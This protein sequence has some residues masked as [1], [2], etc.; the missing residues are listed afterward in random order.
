VRKEAISTD[1]IRL[2]FRQ[3]WN[4]SNGFPVDKTGIGRSVL[5][6]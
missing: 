6:Y 4:K 1:Y 2:V 3:L 5:Q